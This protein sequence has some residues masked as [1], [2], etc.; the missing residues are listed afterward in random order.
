MVRGAVR[1]VLL[2]AIA[3][4][5]TTIPAFAH[6]SFA[7]YDIKKRVTLQGVVK[8]FKFSN[9]H[10]WIYLEVV[11][12]GK[13]EMYRLEGLQVRLVAK[14]G[15]KR[16][17]LKFGDKVSI[18]INP[19]RDGSRGGHFLQVTLADGTVLGNQSLGPGATGT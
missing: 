9:P 15:F 2:I 11:E 14:A 5:L 4:W 17:S 13:P 7:M 19:L 6:H 18:L 1:A 3:A 10:T 16:N 8:V 12:N